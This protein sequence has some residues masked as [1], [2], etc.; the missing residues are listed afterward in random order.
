MMI[1]INVCVGAVPLGAERTEHPEIRRCCLFISSGRGTPRERGGETEA[2]GG[3]AGGEEPGAAQG[4][5]G[6]GVARRPPLR[7]GDSLTL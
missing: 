7:G 4:E 6:G 2:A 1:I 5:P 3:P